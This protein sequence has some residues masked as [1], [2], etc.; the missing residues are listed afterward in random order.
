MS[1]TTET[2]ESSTEVLSIFDL[3]ETD[4]AAEEEGRWFRDIFNDGSNIDVKLRRLT[5]R[6][7]MQARRRLEKGYRRH[8]KNGVYPDDIAV[9]ILVEQIAEAVLVDWKGI[10]DRDK[11]PMEYSK[12]NALALLTKLPVFRDGVIQM[13]SNL[14]NFRIEEKEA[15]SKN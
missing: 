1:D 4:A 5:S 7:S 15:T 2:V 6:S 9:K 8:M 3:C 14:D 11:K 13:A 12:E 10:Y